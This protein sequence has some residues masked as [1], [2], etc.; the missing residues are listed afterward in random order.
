MKTKIF[1]WL[2]TNWLNFYDEITRRGNNTFTVYGPIMRGLFGSL[3][4]NTFIRIRR[5]GKLFEGP[6]HIVYKHLEKYYPKSKNM[7]TEYQMILRRLALRRNLNEPAKPLDEIRRND[8]D[9]PISLPK[10]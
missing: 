3:R 6:L 8:P 2:L 1:E 7:K 10:P 4:P 5:E 9:M